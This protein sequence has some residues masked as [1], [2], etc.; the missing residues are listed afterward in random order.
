MIPRIHSNQ[1]LEHMDDLASNLESHDGVLEF[2]RQRV[3]RK[4]RVVVDV[5]NQGHGI[6]ANWRCFE[7]RIE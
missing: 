6:I 3:W 5:T 1:I 4:N 7:T 2:I